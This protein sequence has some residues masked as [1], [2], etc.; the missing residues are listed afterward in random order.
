MNM[1]YKSKH[2]YAKNQEQDDFVLPIL[3]V[4]SCG[5]DSGSFFDALA[6]YWNDYFA[7][8]CAGTVFSVLKFVTKNAKC[9][10][11]LRR[12]FPVFEH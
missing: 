11:D 3:E 2:E 7:L 6:S 8:N 4:R 9:V 5:F 1:A 10:C 12:S